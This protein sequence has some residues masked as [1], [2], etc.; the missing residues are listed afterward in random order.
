MSDPLRRRE[1]ATYEDLLEVPDH[2][3]AEILD[4]DLYAVPRPAPPHARAASVLGA[5]ILAPFDREGGGAGEPGGWWILDE[6]EI[7]LHEDIVVPDIAGWR[8]SRMPTFPDAAFFV[9]P[10]DWVCEV[11]SPKTERMDRGRKRL[12]YAREGVSH[13]WL[14]SP[15]A[16][17]L[18]IFR[19][20]GDSWTL[21]RTFEGDETIHA[22]PFETVGLEMA[23][24]WIP[25]SP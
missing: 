15:S 1:R 16:R 23:R 24:W 12:I 6:P 9:L 22:E 11:V 18:E 14:L 21:V 20:S 10:P 2:L 13:L 19:L 5:D 8:R 17:T 7:H 4:G 25:S 3:V